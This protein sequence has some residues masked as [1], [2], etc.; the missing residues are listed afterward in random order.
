MFL[1]W[2]KR[3]YTAADTLRGGEKNSDILF[4]IIEIIFFVI[5]F[6]AFRPDKGWN[7]LDIMLLLV[8]TSVAAEVVTDFVFYD[9]PGRICKKFYHAA[10]AYD[11]RMLARGNICWYADKSGVKTYGNAPDAK[12]GIEYFLEQEMKKPLYQVVRVKGK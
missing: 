12:V 8:V 5:F 2:G 3:I 10:Q 1:R 4:G 9:L 6:M 11:M 7:G